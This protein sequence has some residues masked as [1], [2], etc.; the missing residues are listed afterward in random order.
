METKPSKFFG[1][2]N[3][4]G[5]AEDLREQKVA[6]LRNVPIQGIQIEEIDMSSEVYVVKDD[7][8]GN[9]VAYAPVLIIVNADSIDDLSR[10]IV[11]DEFRKIEI[12]EPEEVYY[13]RLDLERFLF[14]TSQ[15]I[16][17]YKSEWE[18][19]ASQR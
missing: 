11:V 10:F 8:S 17:Q 2:K 7:N 6:L 3:I 15:E 4:E 9:L 18:R 14:K 5:L 19:R 13:S 16:R 1:S 12:L